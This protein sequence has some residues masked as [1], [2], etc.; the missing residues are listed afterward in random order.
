MFLTACIVLIQA[1][2]LPVVSHNTLQ[3][4]KKKIIL[5]PADTIEGGQTKAGDYRMVSGNVVFLDDTITLRCDRATDYEQE[6]KIVLDGNVFMTDNSVEIYGEHGVY[7]TDREIGELSGKVRGRMVDN[8]L[9]GK[10]H[11]AVVN[12]ATSQISLYD[13]VLV[14]HHEQ[15]ISGETILLHLKESDGGG[16]RKHVDEIQVINNAF[17]AAPAPSPV[18]H[19]GSSGHHQPHGFQ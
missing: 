10:S 9:A 19:P 1:I 18:P 8:S 15:Q 4:E 2:A 7:Y 5:Q 12:K 3:A 17:F 13:D 14:W 16:K 6:N 11:R